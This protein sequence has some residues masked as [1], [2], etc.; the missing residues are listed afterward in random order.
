MQAGVDRNR[1]LGQK[2]NLFVPAD[3]D[4]GVMALQQWLRKYAGNTL[5]VPLGEELTLSR[6]ELLDRYSSTWP[7]Q[8]HSQGDCELSSCM[9][10]Q[11][12]R[13]SD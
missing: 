13:R 5:P 1:R 11:A 7:R 4:R 3:S 10:S 12:A 8:F 2:D 6:R 9:A